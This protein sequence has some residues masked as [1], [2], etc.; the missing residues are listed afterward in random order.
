VPDPYDGGPDDYAL[1]FDL[2]QPA[3][4]GLAAQLAALLAD[5]PAAPE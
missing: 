4:R 3:A 1:V 5:R 2:V